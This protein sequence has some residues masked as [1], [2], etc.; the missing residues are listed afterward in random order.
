MELQHKCYSVKKSNE[1]SGSKS[2]CNV[3]LDALF[4]EKG[5]QSQPSKIYYEMKSCNIVISLNVKTRF[6]RGFVTGEDT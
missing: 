1:T 6:K 4:I 5:E 3:G 2:F